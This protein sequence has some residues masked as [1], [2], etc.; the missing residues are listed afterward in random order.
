[1][2]V[3]TKTFG[4]PLVWTPASQFEV[5]EGI[6]VVA[7]LFL[8]M[9]VVSRGYGALFRSSTLNWH[10]RS[11]L[12]RLFSALAVAGALSYALLVMCNMGQL[13]AVLDVGN[14]D[15]VQYPLRVFGLVG[16]SA[17]GQYGGEG[18][19]ALA[20]LIWGATILAL[21]LARGFASAV[22][23]FAV[24]SIL[25]LT[26]VVLLYDPGE[27]ASQAVNVVSGI[28]FNGV[29]LLSNWFLLTTSSS[30]TVFELAYEGV[31][32]GR[33]VRFGRPRGPPQPAPGL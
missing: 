17:M 32:R 13:K 24:P 11:P 19:G 3:I 2:S 6:V 21:S 4:G 27:M 18:Y 28:R 7:V 22:K 20:L 16:G 25:F 23:L 31:F 8:L 26:I 33:F 9:G 29:S 30:L 5:V 14:L 15:V 12:S 1:M 10:L